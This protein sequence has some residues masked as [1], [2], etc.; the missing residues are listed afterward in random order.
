MK[1]RLFF[2]FLLGISLSTNAQCP[3]SAFAYLSA[4]STCPTGC[5]VLLVNW[6]EGVLVNIYGGSP[7]SIISSVPIPGTFGGPST[8][9]AFTCVPCNVPLIFASA[10]PGATSG[11]V[12]LNTGGIPIKLVRFEGR[13]INQRVELSWEAENETSGA[14]YTIE[15]SQDGRQ[16]S[17]IGQVQGLNAGPQRNR[18]QYHDLQVPGGQV[19]YRIRTQ[20]SGQ[21][22]PRYSNLLLIRS[23]DSDQSITAFPNPFE[24]SL[25]ISI[26]G[27]QL[28]AWVSLHNAQGA[29]VYHR[30]HRETAFRIE[31]Q[32]PRGVY[33][34][35]LQ[36]TNGK[37]PVIKKL[38]RQ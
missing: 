11:C 33:T 25:A 20:E 32:L 9:N 2:S 36:P 13:F 3:P 5:G 21:P 35:T 8:G 22:A 28:P 19:Y 34:L 38:V 29:R 12:I 10:V 6:P 4:Y 26:S 16:F 17:A 7:I 23:Q 24:N 14:V 27:P 18:Y 31:Q 30:L 1:K 15:R 37:P